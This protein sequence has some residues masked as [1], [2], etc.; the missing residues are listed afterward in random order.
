MSKSVEHFQHAS[1][2]FSFFFDALLNTQQEPRNVQE[3]KNHQMNLLYYFDYFFIHNSN[4][5][6]KKRRQG[7]TKVFRNGIL[8]LAIVNLHF[9]LIR[10]YNNPSFF[11]FVLTSTYKKNFIV[12][13]VKLNS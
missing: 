2:H 13:E 1:L 10:N 12:V 8:K 7:K 6:S 11:A 4:S 3:P 9:H 5:R